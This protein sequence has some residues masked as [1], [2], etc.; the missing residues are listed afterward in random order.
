MNST[1]NV[2][3]DRKMLKVTYTH[4]T[5]DYYKDDEEET[6]DYMKELITCSKCEKETPRKDLY[7]KA[8]GCAYTD[9]CKV[10]VKN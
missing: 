9:I 4:P 3:G 10:C 7:W 5:V 1:K 8:G 6:S 2:K